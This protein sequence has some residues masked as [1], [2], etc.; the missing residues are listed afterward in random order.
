MAIS[1]PDS[2]TQVIDREFS[3]SDRDFERV[4]KLI[5]QQA[6]ISLNDGKHAMVIAACRAVCAKQA[7]SPLTRIFS[8]WKTGTLAASQEWQGIHEL[9]DHQPDPLSSEEHHFHTLAEH[10][11]K[12][13]AQPTRICAA[14][15]PQAK[16]LI[17]GHHGG[18]I[19]ACMPGQDSGQR[20]RHQCADDGLPRVYD[21]G[22]RGLSETRLR[23]FFCAAN[24]APTPGPSGSSPNWPA[25]SSSVHSI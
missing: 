9:P 8:G 17:P 18:R 19:W 7:T 20:H 23:Q 3:F 15:R 22:T 1:M 12:R 25:W 14:P 24:R 16:S 21:A 4:R 2:T 13:G 6:G 10:L 5:Y 11:K